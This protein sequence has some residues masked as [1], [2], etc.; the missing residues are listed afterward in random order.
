MLVLGIV[1]SVA[2]ACGFAGLAYGYRGQR[3][4]EREQVVFLRKQLGTGEP[5]AGTR[6]LTTTHPRAVEGR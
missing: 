5:P 3:D 4:I 2:A 6:A 1:I